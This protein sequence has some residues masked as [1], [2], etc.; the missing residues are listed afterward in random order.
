MHLTGQ[1]GAIIARRHEAICRA[2]ADG[3]VWIGQ[4]QPMDGDTWLQASRGVCLGRFRER[5]CPKARAGFDDI[6]YEERGPV[7]YLHFDFYNGALSTAQCDRLRALMRGRA[8]GR[9]ESSC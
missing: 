2:T 7:G 5:P 3:A 8:G 9:R 6:R 1:A 4:L